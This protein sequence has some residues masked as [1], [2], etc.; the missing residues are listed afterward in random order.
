MKPRR[1]EM[2]TKNQTRPAAKPVLLAS[3]SRQTLGS[4][5]ARMALEARAKAARGK[6]DG[7]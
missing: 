4:L 3:T 6:R 5:M 2:S 1:C 7:E